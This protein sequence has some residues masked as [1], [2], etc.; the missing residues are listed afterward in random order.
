VVIVGADL[1]TFLHVHPVSIDIPDGA[2]FRVPVTF[3]SA[4]QYAVTVS[5]TV[6]AQ[7]NE[8]Q[9]AVQVEGAPAMAEVSARDGTLEQTQEGITV[10]LDTNGPLTVG[11]WEKLA[12]TFRDASGDVL[13]LQPYLGAPMHVAVVRADLRH[14][15]HAHGVL[16]RAWWRSLTEGSLPP[17]VHPHVSLPAAFGPRIE[18]PLSFPTPGRYVIFSEYQRNGRVGIARFEVTVGE[19]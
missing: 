17:S 15:I 5:Y 1:E 12:Y 7:S 2:Q 13:D 6:R 11:T 16:P 10:A 3:P 19:P 14:L 4:G 8:Q 18:V 9:F